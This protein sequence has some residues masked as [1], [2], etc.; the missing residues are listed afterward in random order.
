MSVSVSVCLAQSPDIY[1]DLKYALR[2]CTK[3]NKKTASV[4]IYSAMGLFEE[5]VELAL[6][7]DVE[8]AMINADKPE[9][10][11]ELRKKVRQTNSMR[12]REFVSRVNI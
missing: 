10:D 8:L 4:L 1:F 12:E 6:Q 3:F 5:A 2:L 7:V 9:D 11:Q